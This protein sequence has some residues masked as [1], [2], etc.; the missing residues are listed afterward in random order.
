MEHT[1]KP[2]AVNYGPVFSFREFV[3]FTSC[4]SRSPHLSLEQA[5]VSKERET[6]RE[7]VTERPVW[8][9]ICTAT[10]DCGNNKSWG[11]CSP[12]GVGKRLP[13][14]PF[15]KHK[16]ERPPSGFL[17]SCS[18]WLRIEALAVT[19]PQT[20][21]PGVGVGC[22]VTIKGLISIKVFAQ[23][24]PASHTPDL[25]VQKTKCKLLIINSKKRGFTVRQLSW[26]FPPPQR[27]R[28]LFSRLN[29]S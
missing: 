18:A 9:F 10:E 28:W 4:P 23:I 17:L 8:H 3:Y 1:K 13:M 15:S 27:C 2:T 19:P 16:A 26:P 20:S 12:R 7:N 11:I 14:P 5:N 25:H 21:G 6:L 24:F 22:L 29:I